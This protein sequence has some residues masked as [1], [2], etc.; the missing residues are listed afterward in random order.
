MFARDSACM[1]AIAAAMP[2]AATATPMFA[3]ASRV[4]LAISPALRAFSTVGADRHFAS[5]TMS[6][7]GHHVMA[8][9]AELIAHDQV[10][11]GAGETRW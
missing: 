2:N 3:S 11:A 10:V 4:K 5:S 9:A 8:V 6:L 7:A 1:I